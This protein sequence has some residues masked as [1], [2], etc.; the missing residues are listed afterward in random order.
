MVLRQLKKKEMNHKQ[1]MLRYK[2]IE[3]SE[4]IQDV[5]DAGNQK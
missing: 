5:F 1:S 4:I 3:L 2:L